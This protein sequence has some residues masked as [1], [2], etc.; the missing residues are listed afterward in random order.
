MSMSLQ[1]RAIKENVGESYLDFFSSSMLSMII[2]FSAF[3][4]IWR[5]AAAPIIKKKCRNNVL[6]RVAMF[7]LLPKP[8][9][10]TF[11]D[12]QAQ[13]QAS[14]ICLF[15][16]F[17]NS[18]QKWETRNKDYLKSCSEG[19][20][21]RGW[22]SRRTNHGG[23]SNSWWGGGDKYL[24]CDDNGGDDDYSENDYDCDDD[25]DKLIKVAAEPELFLW[26]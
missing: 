3:Q 14:N 23:S 24:E 7:E 25:D 19:W 5:I 15:F 2:F 26:H 8:L 16:S 20:R 18:H 12:E 10:I 9:M 6:G 22:A 1:V 21:S 4:S 13:N 17:W 11:V